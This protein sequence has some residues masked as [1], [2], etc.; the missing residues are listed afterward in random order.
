MQD[1][2]GIVSNLFS[3]DK[4]VDNNA[5]NQKPF[6]TYF[7]GRFKGLQ[8]VSPLIKELQILVILTCILT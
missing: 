6:R 4:L 3:T 8:M 1:L 2:L 7:I 5:G